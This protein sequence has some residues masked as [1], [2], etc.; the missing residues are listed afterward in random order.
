MDRRFSLGFLIASGAFFFFI[1]GLTGYRIQDARQ[2]NADDARAQLPQLI[3]R[4]G[5]LRTVTGGYDA[6][7]FK[8][9]MRSLFDAQPRLL[10]LSIHSTDG[11][12]YL[13]TRDKA[14][15][16]DPAE[17]TPSWRGTPSYNLSRGYETLLSAPVE[18]AN[19]AA[20]DTISVIMG[21]E[22]LYPIV[23]DD[24]YLFLAFLLVCGVLM[25]IVFGVQQEPVR[26][27]AEPAQA[28][29]LAAPAASPTPA[30]QSS[31][32]TAEPAPAA[33]LGPA[34]VVVPAPAFTPAF[35]PAFAPAAAPARS[36][37]S[38]T[39]GLVWAEHLQERLS[40][41]IERAAAG[42]QDIACGRVK[43]DGPFIGG[44]LPAL[45]AEVAGAMKATF[46]QQDLLFEGGDDSYTVVLP[47][48]SLDSA[49]RLFEELRRKVSQVR[50]DGRSPSLSIG[51]SSRGGRLIDHPTLL[52][53]A[54]TA[55]AKASR[56][57]GNQVIGFRADAARYRE[58][59][60][61]APA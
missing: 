58:V 45:Y 11:M 56:E 19:A 10:L 22:D 51:V 41:E 32:R 20:M 55:M 23:R 7:Q 37:T 3:Q 57:G 49:V 43:L 61:G 16:Q 52:E 39:T 35:A 31:P 15:L 59:L 34:P 42:D 1:V 18:G 6:P 12:L 33:P 27:R 46:A 9:G 13:V 26:G 2:R 4:A 54:G 53:E 25:L 38:P 47:D 8:K 30:A 21:R 36:L 40:A 44:S 28:S 14:L 48:T 5:S 29:G 60:T 24:L 17:V 50:R